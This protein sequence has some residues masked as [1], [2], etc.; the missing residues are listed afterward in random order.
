VETRWYVPCIWPRS[1]FLCS[2]AA[3]PIAI[4]PRSVGAGGGC[5]PR[6]D[7]RSSPPAPTKIKV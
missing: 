7:A 3:P 4:S 6:T 2:A 1:S 5:K